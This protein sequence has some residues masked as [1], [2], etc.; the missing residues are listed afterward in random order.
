MIVVALG[1]LWMHSSGH[2]GHV[3]EDHTASHAVEVTT[4]MASDVDAH[5]DGAHRHAGA[6]CA[7]MLT[8]MCL[9]VLTILASLLGPPSLIAQ[10]AVQARDSARLR[11][12]AFLTGVR[13]SF[14]ELSVFRI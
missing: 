14:M 10:R 5:E 6:L 4:P 13:C 11:A 7:A 1:V 8:A 2:S 3:C 9:A 12:N